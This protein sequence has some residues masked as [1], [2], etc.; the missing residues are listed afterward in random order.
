M[1]ITGEIFQI[2]GP[3]LTAAQDAAVY[4]IRVEGRGA[5]V[6]AGTGRD[7]QGL[8]KHMAARGVPPR[9][10]EYLLLTHCHYDHSG[11]AADIRQAA[12]GCRVVA[13]DLEAPF[14]ESGDPGVTAAAWYGADLT[15]VRVDLKIRSGSETVMLGMRPIEAIHIPG[16]SPGSLAY[17]VESE[18]ARVLFG[19]DVHGPLDPSLRSDARDYRQSLKRLA[20]LEADILC[21]GHY[22]VFRGKDDVRRFI[23][24]FL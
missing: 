4:L 11:G 1:K 12:H 16:H 18:G 23:E 22:G 24:G 14:L 3:G 13:H 10:L 8:L 21:E 19:Q 17:L 6:D 5:L 2:G 7:I 20:A 15:P 9:D